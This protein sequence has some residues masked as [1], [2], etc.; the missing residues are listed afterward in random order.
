[1]RK[2]AKNGFCALLLVA[3]QLGSL[4]AQTEQEIRVENIVPELLNGQLVISAEFKNLFSRRIVGTI[5]SGLPS[6]IQIEIKVVDSTNHSLVRKRL[7]R[8]LSYDLWEERYT[9]KFQDTTLTFIEF[10]ALKAGSNNLKQLRLLIPQALEPGQRY[11]ITLR[12]G[13][14]PITSRQAEKVTDWLLNPNQTDEYIASD[15]RA[16]GFQLNLNK[17]VSFFATNRKRSIFT[18]RWFSSENFTLS[19]LQ[20]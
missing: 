13:I 6:I 3:S 9:L 4:Y 1:M 2:A 19:D 12:V 7:S 18:S 8:T 16:S 5:Q 14:V 17:L 20:E 11:Q 10:A 15:E